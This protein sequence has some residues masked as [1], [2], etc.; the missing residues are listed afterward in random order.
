MLTLSLKLMYLTHILY[1]IPLRMIFF[2]QILTLTCA[3]MRCTWGGKM[4]AILKNMLA[5]LHI[6]ALAISMLL[7]IFKC[8]NYDWKWDEHEPD[9]GVKSNIKLSPICLRILDG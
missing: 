7:C 1:S 6:A 4:K 8:N 3:L 5:A 9:H 2:L